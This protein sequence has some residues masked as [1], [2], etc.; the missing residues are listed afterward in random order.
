MPRDGHLFN[1]DSLVTNIWVIWVHDEVIIVKVPPKFTV[2]NK[3]RL[4]TT[5]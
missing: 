1:I 2:E 5:V 3:R 4:E